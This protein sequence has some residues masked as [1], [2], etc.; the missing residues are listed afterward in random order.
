MDIVNQLP[1]QRYRKVDDLLAFAAIYDDEKR[2]QAYKR[3]L[4]RHKKQIQGS[5]CLEV[6]CGFGL[7]S[8]YLAKLGAKRVY[9][10]EINPT[11]AAIAR[12]RLMPYSQV[13][14]VQ[15]DIRDFLP[16]E[17]VQVLVQELYGQMLLDEDLIVL[18]ELR[19]SP[20]WVF[21]NGGRLMAGCSSSRQLCDDV[22]TPRL[23]KELDGVLVSGLFDESGL[24]L[25]LPVLEWRYGKTHL[26][27]I[28]DITPL[29]GDVLYL[30]LQIEHDGRPVCR[31]SV[32][33]NWSY[34]WTPRCGDHFKLCFKPEMDGC[35]CTVE[36]DWV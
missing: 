26:E 19:F 12:E 34:I 18:D 7:F 30:G 25:E 29:D 5:V 17:P 22:V 3:L 35:G 14:V 2:E 21:P 13:T 20:K 33:D 15:S 36:F 9:A 27:A 32:C 28:G 16:P 23:L 24:S 31:A 6:G 1:L 11:M 10:V 8:E 4:L